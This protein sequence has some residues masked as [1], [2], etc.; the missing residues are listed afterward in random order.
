M[1]NGRGGAGVVMATCLKERDLFRKHCDL[2]HVEINPCTT[3][4]YLLRRSIYILLDR[5]CIE[6]ELVYESK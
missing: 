4:T 1:K 6:L 5:F 2:I 3:T